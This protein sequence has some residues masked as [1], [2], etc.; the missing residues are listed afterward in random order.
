M[1][2]TLGST[3]SRATQGET[4][5]A[6]RSKAERSGLGDRG[7][8]A[9]HVR[10]HPSLATRDS[11]GVDRLRRAVGSERADDGSGRE[12]VERIRKV[13]QPLSGIVTEL[14]RT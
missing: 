6:E 11:V 3:A 12:S 1:R 14:K 4:D 9:K 5:E 10:V 8:V 7:D 13:A 2:A